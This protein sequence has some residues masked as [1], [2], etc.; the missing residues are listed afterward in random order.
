MELRINGFAL[1][2]LAFFTCGFTWGFGKEDPC[3]E[4]RK[5]VEGITPGVTAPERM[6]TEKSV[7]TLCPDGG[8]EHYQKG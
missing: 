1:I 8:A 7:T 2:L 6:K 5:S 3:V 4:S